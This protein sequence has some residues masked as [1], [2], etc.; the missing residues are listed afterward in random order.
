MNTMINKAKTREAAY[1][2][3]RGV[4]LL[5]IVETNHVK[6]DESEVSNLYTDLINIADQVMSSPPVAF[7]YY[8]QRTEST[9]Y[10]YAYAGWVVDTYVWLIDQGLDGSL[11]SESWHVFQGLLFGYSAEAIGEFLHKD[12][13]SRT[14][15]PEITIKNTQ[16]LQILLKSDDADVLLNSGDTLTLQNEE[17]IVDGVRMHGVVSATLMQANEV[18]DADPSRGDDVHSHSVQEV[19]QGPNLHTGSE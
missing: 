16:G 6:L 11:P 3:A 14:P 10:G 8:C 1:L 2:V 13:V 18:T 9:Y 7:V 17:S 19:T 15:R 4:R 12:K 5:A